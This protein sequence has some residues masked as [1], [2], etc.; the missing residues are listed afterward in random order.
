MSREKQLLASF[1]SDFKKGKKTADPMEYAK[2]SRTLISMYGSAESVAQKLGV[3]KETVRILSKVAD[4]PS[5]VQ[6]LISQRKIPITVAF[7]LVPLDRDKQIEAAKVV[8]SL[9][10][11]DARKVIRRISENPDKSVT[12]VRAE[13]LSELEKR[14]VNIAMIALPKETY[15]SLEEQSKDVAALISHIVED[16]LAKDS[17]LDSYYTI[18]KRDLVSLKVIFSRSTFMKLRRRTRKP[19]NLVEQ[20]VIDWLKQKGKIS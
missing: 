3:G 13:V 18:Q 8:T 17:T 2:A 9:P 19:A 11:K 14:E 16:W 15:A 5:E 10:F 20:I 1:I 6:N 12:S 4:L 7:D